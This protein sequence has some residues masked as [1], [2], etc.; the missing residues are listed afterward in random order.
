[1][2][3]NKFNLLAIPAI[4]IIAIA[5]YAN[6]LHNQFVYDD[7]FL[8]QENSLI[9]SSTFKPE[10]FTKNI[11]FGSGRKSNFYRPLQILSYKLDY[12]FWRL[13]P[14]GYHITNILLHILVALSVYFLL[15][16]ILR[17]GII[18]FLTALI[19]VSHPVHTEAV[20]YISGRADPLAALF[21]IWAFYF[22]VRY[23]KASKK[24]FYILSIFSFI[25]ALFSREN[26]LVFLF[27][28]I[29]YDY[30]L[31]RKKDRHLKNYIP[32][33][34]F[35]LLYLFLR[36][37]ILAVPTTAKQYVST[38]LIERIP[39]IFSSITE[40]LR[41]LIFPV[42]L[43]MEYIMRLYP[44]FNVKT[45]LGV[46]IAAVSIIFALTSIKKRP[47]ISFAIFWFWI[48]FIPASNI[49]PLK[50][51]M[52]EHWLYLPSIGF[53]LLLSYLIKKPLLSEHRQIRLVAIV[54][55]ISGLSFYSAL[56]VY[57]NR[58]WKDPITFYERTLKFSPQSSR[59]HNSL[60][61]EYFY[62]GEYEKAKQEFKKA[63]EIKP[64]HADAYNNLGTTYLS[65]GQPEKAKKFFKK[66]LTLHAQQGNI[67][68]AGEIKEALGSL[69]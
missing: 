60:G 34:L 15:K 29:M 44:F 25:L 46:I 33:I 13:N 66:A 1:M 69:K 30:V 65:L 24:V 61:G 48:N 68:K 11:G 63:I 28:L 20:T 56:T 50:A 17:D 26:A 51:F 59:L 12:Y 62:R 64:T 22:H 21:F 41:I 45:I 43:H 6:S 3:K 32:F 42:D 54:L 9:K 52:A 18:A 23:Q 37:K 14:K 27:V 5:V 19:F 7:E 31:T 58:F 47:I 2:T 38:T 10:L 8:I 55:L 36:I 4:V 49:F 57:Q 35:S 16:L 40:Y 67:E 53:F 39:G